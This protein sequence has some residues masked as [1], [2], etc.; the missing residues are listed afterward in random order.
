MKVLLLLTLSILLLPGTALSAPADITKETL[1]SGGEKRSFYAFIPETAA[2]SKSA[3][4]V[5]L[6]HGAGRNARVLV[7]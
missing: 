2:A 7:E 4:L 6:L 5:V 3:P 1:V